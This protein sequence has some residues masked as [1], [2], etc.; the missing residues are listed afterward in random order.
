[1]VDG[2]GGMRRER[3]MNW[4]GGWGRMPREEEEGLCDL[5]IIPLPSP[6]FSLYFYFRLLRNGYR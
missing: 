4:G 6:S 2:R 3:E 1:M 5:T